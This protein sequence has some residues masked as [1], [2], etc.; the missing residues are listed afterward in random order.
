MGLRSKV[1][2]ILTALKAIFRR[3]F[4][5][6]LLENKYRIVPAF[7]L[8]GKKYFMFADQQ[9]VPTGRQMSALAI[10]MEMEMRMDRSYVEMHTR[11]MDKLLNNGKSINVGIIAQLNANMKDRLE[12][13]VT[14][15]FIYKLASVVFF[16]ESESPYMYD[17]E[18][19]EK[20]IAAWKAEEK[21]LAFFLQTPLT[22]L[23]PL[24]KAQQDVSPIYSVVA[25]MVEKTHHKLLTDILS[26]VPSPTE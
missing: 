9:E 16:D 11:A 24:L 19:N 4:R 17:F 2:R 10:Y 3:P 21:M 12:L 6:Y 25:E 14:P 18:Y 15:M 20:K 7:E 5:S 23:V 22:G 8:H 26:E 1:T 13:M